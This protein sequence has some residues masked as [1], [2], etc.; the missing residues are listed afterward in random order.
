MS[1]SCKSVVT[2]QTFATA[3]FGGL[4]RGKVIQLHMEPR[5]LEHFVNRSV[6]DDDSGVI[7]SLGDWLQGECHNAKMILF[8]RYAPPKVFSSVAILQ[9]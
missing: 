1:R 3:F 4:D 8:D 6:Q 9:I 7:E 5:D 2:G